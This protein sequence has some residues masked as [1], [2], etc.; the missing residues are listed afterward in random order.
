[1]LLRVHREYNP[2]LILVTENGAA[3]AD[4]WDGNNPVRD[5]R[6][7]Q[8]LRDHIYAIESAHR[9]GVP[10]GG[11]FIWSLLD[12]Y[13]WNEGYSKRFGIIYVDFATGRRQI[14]ESGRWYASFIKAQQQEQQ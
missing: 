12:N 13:E 11:Y 8:Y 14:K 4:Q 5:E 10:V 3:F 7:A 2:R 9:Q 6:R 1:V